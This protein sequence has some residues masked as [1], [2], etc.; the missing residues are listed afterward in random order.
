VKSTPPPIE[1]FDVFQARRSERM[2]LA[3]D[4][5]QARKAQE[6]RDLRF[7]LQDVLMQLTAAQSLFAEEERA[8]RTERESLVT[9]FERIKAEADIAFTKSQTEHL[10][11]KEELQR[12]QN[13]GFRKLAAQIPQLT[14]EQEQRGLDVETEEYQK[15]KK[16]EN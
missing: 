10:A 14:A 12:S 4:D 9:D 16:V 15:L 2:K 3:S 6:V 8:F 13:E 11:R 1:S 5:L 7:R